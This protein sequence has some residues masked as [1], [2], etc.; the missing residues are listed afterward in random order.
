MA[1]ASA[2]LAMAAFVMTKWVGFLLPPPPLQF[3]E[4][5]SFWLPLATVI[6]GVVCA[7]VFLFLPWKKKTA[8]QSKVALGVSTLVVVVAL[9]AISI[10]YE[11]QRSKWTFSF[12]G[13]SVLIGDRY[14]EPGGVDAKTPGISLPI[15]F[16]DF[17]DK[18]YEVW[19]EAGLQRRQ[20][21]LG[22]IYLFASLTG[23]VCFALAAWVVLRFAAENS[24]KN[25]DARRP[26]IKAHPQKSSRSTRPPS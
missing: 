4:K 10:G 25:A 13:A 26:S 7:V 21:R 14:T 20:L 2:L 11:Y 24:N 19:T 8:M 9:L 5:D 17:G 3:G 22:A 1:A 15:L 18:S 12:Q 23:G 6:T 16:H